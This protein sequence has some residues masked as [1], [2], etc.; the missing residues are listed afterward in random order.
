MQDAEQ[1][2]RRETGQQQRYIGDSGAEL[3]ALE[4][5]GFE[6]GY[7]STT[8]GNA[9][10][11]TAD[12]IVAAAA[13]ACGEALA[14]YVFLNRDAF[15]QAYTHGWIAGCLAAQRAWRRP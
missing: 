11:E 4:W 12:Q 5:E 8:A 9:T 13:D 7:S 1:D 14:D 10:L 15:H 6:Q 3:L 2:V